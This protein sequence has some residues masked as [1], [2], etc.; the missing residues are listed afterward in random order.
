MKIY[1]SLSREKHEFLPAQ[2]EVRMYVCGVTP[3]S[4]SHVGHAMS[5][6]IFDVVRRYLEFIGYQVHHVQNFTDIDDKLIDRAK[7]E[8]TT[9]KTTA[10]RNIQG[11][12]DDMDALNIQRAH[13]YPKASEEVP[14]MIAII[15]DLISNG[16][17]YESYGDVYFRVSSLTNYGKL[18]HRTLDGMR[19]G[20]RIE[21]N[22]Q[23]AHPMDFA[24]WKSTKPGEPWW[25]SPW[26]KGRPGWHIECTAMAMGYL[27]ETID[28]HGGG[29][30]LIFP[31]HE[32][33]IAQSEAF[34]GVPFARFWMHN[35]LLHMDQEKMS[36]SMGNLITIRDALS[37]V[38]ADSIR[39][40]VLNSHY[41][42]PTAYSD[43]VLTSAEKAV[44]RLIYATTANNAK[45]PTTQLDPGPYRERFISSMDDDFNTP[46]A[47]AALFDLAH[48][49][50][51]ASD[52]GCGVEE[53]QRTL[54]ELGRSVL[55]FQLQK[56]VREIPSYLEQ[57]AKKL[58]EERNRLRSEK[59]FEEADNTRS[60]L[61]GMGITITDTPDG[62]SWEWNGSTKIDSD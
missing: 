40:S 41:R 35:G 29:Q 36:K 7:V 21:P 46:Q 14:S 18:S 31:H 42:S 2:E 6:I 27:G 43:E 57:L 34:S 25:E 60:T 17:A 3:Y 32:N 38:S 45:I 39:F 61:T 15:D 19:A 23:K 5:Y 49:I 9:V 24:L 8:G 26:G 55:G 20:A 10:E 22:D 1:D 33:E 28:L 56:D 47:L 13:T 53:A 52:S 37:K 58:V 59:R 12:F 16:F 48:E 62:T 30:D 50:N 44:D 51:R 11:Y 4:E 54:L